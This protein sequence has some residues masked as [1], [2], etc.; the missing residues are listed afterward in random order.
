MCDK[1]SYAVDSLFYVQERGS[2]LANLS[3]WK[4]NAQGFG[5]VYLCFDEIKEKV[6]YS[7]RGNV[8][9]KLVL[10]L[11]KSEDGKGLQKMMETYNAGR[12]KRISIQPLT[13]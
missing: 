3:D 4:W 11:R 12:F 13:K 9:G 5:E 1:N 7:G 8:E 6:Q 10:E 2:I